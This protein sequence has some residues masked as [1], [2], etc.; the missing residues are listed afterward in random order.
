VMGANRMT[1]RCFVTSGWETAD[2]RAASEPAIVD[3]R[4]EATTIAGAKDVEVT[5]FE[6]PFIEV[7]QP[8]VRG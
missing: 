6:V 3:Q 2:D 7:K 8:A 5:L 4:R 1:G